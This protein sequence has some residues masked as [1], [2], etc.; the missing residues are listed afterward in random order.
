MLQLMESA[1]T[2]PQVSTLQAPSIHGVPSCAVVNPSCAIVN[3]MQAPHHLEVYSQVRNLG[4]PSSFTKLGG[5]H[6]F[7]DE[8]SVMQVLASPQEGY[9]S[10]VQRLK[11]IIDAKAMNRRQLSICRKDCK[12][13]LNSHQSFQCSK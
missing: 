8:G 6:A 7:A 13:P 9:Y 4:T 2:T 11:Q 10:R 1:V 5:P 3:P 12:Q